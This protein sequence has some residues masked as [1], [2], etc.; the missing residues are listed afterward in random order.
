VLYPP[1]D[2]TYWTPGQR[3]GSGDYYLFT[4]RLV[5]YKQAETAMKA[6]EAAGAQLIIAG[7]GPE[8]RR[9]KQKASPGID[10]VRQPSRTQLRQ[11]YRNA[12]ALVFPGVEDFGMTLVEAQACGTPVL[13]FDQ[14]GARETVVDGLTGRLY[15]DA[16][17][18][19]LATE[20]QCFDPSSYSV[21]DLV[22]NARLFDAERF[23]VRL[24]RIVDAAVKGGSIGVASSADL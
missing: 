12:R 13:A 5:A 15:S 21:P 7:S 16:G 20:M 19:S 24:R 23:D 11:L 22:E 3:N 14:G 1:I 10:F 9:L 4:G 8:L 2:T 17:V 6:A 18:E